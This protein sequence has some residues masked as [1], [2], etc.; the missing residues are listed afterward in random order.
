MIEIKIKT[1]NFVE[2]SLRKESSELSR[3]LQGAIK[4]A[5]FLVQ[6][7]LTRNI[8]RGSK[9]GR[10]YNRRGITHRASAPGEYPASDTGRLAGSIRSEFDRLTGIV[11]SDLIYAG[12][13]WEP[14]DESRKRKGLD[15]AYKEVEDKISLLI[16]KAIR[17]AFE[18]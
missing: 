13:L 12:Y 9:T 6:A 2:K 11:G 4:R 5:T 16:D 17:D 3:N 14:A 7:T 10:E 18:I 15:D 8:Q 1:D